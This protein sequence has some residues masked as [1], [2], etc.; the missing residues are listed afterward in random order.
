MTD[1]DPFDTARRRA[2]FGDGLGQFQPAA[3]GAFLR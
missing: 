2:C 3:S 1:P